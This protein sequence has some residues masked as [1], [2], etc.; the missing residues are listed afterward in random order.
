LLINNDGQEQLPIGADERMLRQA[1]LNLLRNGAE[2]IPE[3]KV[4]RVVEVR[5]TADTD[6]SGKRWAGI[7]V[8]DSGSGIPP[9][10]LQK[11]SIPFCTT[12]TKGHGVGLALPH[13]AITEHGGSLTAANFPGG[14]AIF[15]VRLPAQGR[16]Q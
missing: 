7:E 1:L 5:A 9:A 6:G 4:E 11:I 10:Q 15:T 3:N 2:A 8:R 16:R 14:G 12:K 13:R